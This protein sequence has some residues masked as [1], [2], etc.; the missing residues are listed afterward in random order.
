MERVR[1]IVC[2]REEKMKRKHTKISHI[3]MIIK[4]RCFQ[5]FKVNIYLISLY[6]SLHFYLFF[7]H[8]DYEMERIE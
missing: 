5:K 2:Q 1:K 4:F 6:L 8:S 3:Q 7:S